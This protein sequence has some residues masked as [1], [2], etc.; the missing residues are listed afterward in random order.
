MSRPAPLPIRSA[1]MGLLLALLC[2]SCVSCT[3]TTT[4]V[5]EQVQATASIEDPIRVLQARAELESLEPLTP[6]DE[7]LIRELVQDNTPALTPGTEAHR[8]ALMTAD[9]IETPPQL[10]LPADQPEVDPVRKG[11][12][13]KLYT[14]ARMLRQKGRAADAAGVL[15]QALELDPNSAEL[16][17]AL[18]DARVELGDAVGAN[19]AYERAIELGDRTGTT[20]VYVA[21]QAYTLGNDERVMGLCMMALDG[22]EI[23]RDP[24]ARVLAGIM[25]G[26]AQIR[27][28]YLRAGAQSLEQ[29]LSAFN[30]S[31]RDPRW[32]QETIQI[33]GRQAALWVVVGDAWSRVGAH[34]RAADA[35]TRAAE[36]SE[37]VTSGLTARQIAA[38]LRDGHP[39]TAAL[40]LIEHLQAHPGQTGWQEARWVRTLG[41]VESLEGVLND[42]IAS[43]RSSKGLPPSVRRSLLR[44]E[45]EGVGPED[46][47]M[48]LNAA[49]PDANDPAALLTVLRRVPNPDEQVKWSLRLVRSNPAAANALADALNATSVPVLERLE[50]I[51]SDSDESQ[52]LRTALALGL[53]RTDLLA[54]L[55]ELNLDQAASK[56][57]PWI[58][59]HAQAAA[60]TGRWDVAS[61][62]R[63]VLESRAEQSDRAATR[64]LA[65]V[66]ILLQNPNRASDLIQTLCESQAVST[67]DLLL[68][69]RI[70]LA[71]E[72]AET[73]ISALKKARLLDPYDD[74]VSDRMIRLYGNG[75]PLENEDALREVIRE[76]GANRPR[77]DLFVL[78]RAGD[79][80]RNGLLS[81]SESMLIDLNDHRDTDLLGEDLL[82]S[83]WKTR[84]G[85]ND[86]DALSRGM[87]WLEQRLSASPNAI[88]NGLALA[89]IHYELEQYDRSMELLTQLWDRTGSYEVARVRENLVTNELSDPELT[90]ELVDNRLHDQRGIDPSIE[91]ANLLAARGDAGSALQAVELLTQNIPAHTTL[92]PSQK[93]QM[94][95]VVY[96]MAE[97][98]ET[99]GIDEAMLAM[100]NLIEDRTGPLDFFMARTKVLL[101]SRQLKIKID[102][103]LEMVEQYAAT[104]E[105]PE[106]ARVLKALPVQ[107]LLGDD[108]PHEAIVYVTKLALMNDAIDEE[109]LIEV[110]RLLGAV[111]VNSDLLGV[112]D[113][114]EAAGVMQQAIV[115]ST[116]VL[117]TPSRP[118]EGLIDDEQRA[119]LAYTAGAMASAFERP[120]QAEAYLTL[121]LSFDPE[122]GWSNNDL[123]YML[124]E[125]GER[126]QDAGQML[127]T[128]A[129]VL[130]NEASVIDSL[131]WL[132]Y[133]QGVLEDE[134]DPQTQEVS[135]RGAISILV[136]A[137]R[138]DTQRSNATILEH[139]GDALWRA[140]R[141]EH[142]VE[143]WLG[144][145]NMLRS[146]I[147]TLSAQPEP[148]RRAIEAA[149]TELRGLRYRIQDA[150]AG[151]E[152]DIAPVFDDESSN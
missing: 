65:E 141:K 60:L 13:T 119:D 102:D 56:T 85:Q 75:G 91:Y 94:A 58:E 120:E 1:G 74:R 54:H 44:L 86:P 133:K 116:R 111:G 103:L 114:F 59:S 99:E 125:R 36:L 105:V 7:S 16:A 53:G 95:Q 25:L 32:R 92:L 14:R 35:Y 62:L 19:E 8:K 80:A 71:Q 83:I 129:R 52:L 132:R 3:S 49:G 143:T 84:Q 42:A 34:A 27:T 89:Q 47:L 40:L 122:H 145:E 77:S 128:A 127:E 136:R 140:G 11:H 93:R 5:Q 134:K 151:G 39:A 4:R 110:F 69:S 135:R 24:V 67:N 113:E 17:A 108:R 41:K 137:N 121:S 112:I 139:L 46:A 81:E 131:G 37:G 104:M 90:R 48:R 123:G 33:L 150:E 12:A 51:K 15:E 98:A 61:S 22:E 43:L 45:L 82:L 138:L 68:W 30:P 109:S 23:E 100:V 63:D 106:N 130:P 57:V 147:R 142:A 29:A 38:N 55:D 76:L 6:A 117:G 124:T 72:D 70:A 10:S 73:A 20:L 31:L 144:A 21:S 87:A 88:R 149:S 78:L 152:P 97:H 96:S 64:A 26:N 115:I 28:G 66:S 118:T 79:L 18:G 146:R 2:G 101:R 9:Q 126:I 107:V 148:N 50:S